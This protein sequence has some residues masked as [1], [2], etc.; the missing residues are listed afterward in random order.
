MGKWSVIVLNNKNLII[1][2]IQLS[3]DLIPGEMR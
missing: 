1:N 2:T 3:I